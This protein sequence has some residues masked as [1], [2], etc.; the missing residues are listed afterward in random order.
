MKINLNLKVVGAAFSIFVLLLPSCF[1]ALFN[2][3]I[4]PIVHILQILAFAFIV[5]RHSK[6][7]LALMPFFAFLF[8]IFPVYDYLSIAGP[9]PEIAYWRLPHLLGDIFSSR[10]PWLAVCLCM[11]WLLRRSLER[12]R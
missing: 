5:R 6:V 12:E 7:S 11:L 10:L 1:Y 2:G 8:S 4:N 9:W 3:L